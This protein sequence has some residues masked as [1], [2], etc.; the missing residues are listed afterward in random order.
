MTKKHVVGYLAGVAFF[1]DL[2]LIAFIMAQLIFVM[3]PVDISRQV[4]PLIISLLVFAFGGSLL[5]YAGPQ[6]NQRWLFQGMAWV[7]T[8]AAAV[9]LVE[10]AVL[11]IMRDVD[12]T[13]FQW[14]STVTVPLLVTAMGLALGYIAKMRMATLTVVYSIVALVQ[15]G[16]WVVRAIAGEGGIAIDGLFF[17]NVTLFLIMMALI[18]IA[19]ALDKA[20]PDSAEGPNPTPPSQRSRVEGVSG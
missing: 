5:A 6:E 18:G 10:I 1:A 17:G 19:V 14:V 12:I 20:R 16:A 13:F 7:Y 11:F 2:I 9:M 4:A 15:A 8:I 3:Q